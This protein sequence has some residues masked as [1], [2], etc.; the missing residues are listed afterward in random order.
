V[1]LLDLD[2]LTVEVSE[3]VVVLRRLGRKVG[4]GA[5]DLVIRE[6]LA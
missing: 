6:S 2:P 4:N 3:G 1:A 5:G